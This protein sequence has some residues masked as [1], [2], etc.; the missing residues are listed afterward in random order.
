MTALSSDPSIGES[1]N[2]AELIINTVSE[3]YMK[4]SKKSPRRE[5]AIILDVNIASVYD[6]SMELEWQQPYFGK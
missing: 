2:S 4:S 6:D 5:R 3:N 1:G